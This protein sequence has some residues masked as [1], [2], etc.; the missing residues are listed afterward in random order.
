MSEFKIQQWRPVLKLNLREV[1]GGC[2][3]G[4]ITGCAQTILQPSEQ[5]FLVT[6]HSSVFSVH[7]FG[8]FGQGEGIGSTGHTELPSI[9]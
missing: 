5:H 2:D 6:P 3:V 8:L 1:V 4:T 7:S 9:K